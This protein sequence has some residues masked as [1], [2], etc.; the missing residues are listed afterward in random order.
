MF[1]G[2]DRTSE[3]PGCNVQDGLAFWTSINPHDV[4]GSLVHALECAPEPRPILVIGTIY[5]SQ[6]Q[7]NCGALGCSLKWFPTTKVRLEI[8]QCRVV[9]PKRSPLIDGVGH[10][11]LPPARLDQRSSDPQTTGEREVGLSISWRKPVGFEIYTFVLRD[12]DLRHLAA[13]DEGADAAASHEG[14]ARIKA[15]RQARSAGLGV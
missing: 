11:G 3:F 13:A 8:R 7:K 9:N 1:V 12:I 14:K 10:T 5:R 2:I 15:D 4:N 6:W